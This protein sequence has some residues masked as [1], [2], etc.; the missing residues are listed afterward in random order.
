M[1]S[2]G[3]GEDL[4]WTLVIAIQKEFT[5]YGSSDPNTR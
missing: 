1:A 3:S 4:G 2:K 5:E